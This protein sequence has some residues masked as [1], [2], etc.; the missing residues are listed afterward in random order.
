MGWYQSK[1]FNTR[2]EPPGPATA[3][4]SRTRH[5]RLSASPDSPAI[6]SRRGARATPFSLT[7]AREHASQGWPRPE[8]CGH[9][10]RGSRSAGDGEVERSSPS[11]LTRS[12]VEVRVPTRRALR[13]RSFV[14]VH[15]AVRRLRARRP[16]SLRFAPSRAVLAL[17]AYACRRGLLGA[18][19]AGWE[20]ASGWWS[21]QGAAPP[22]WERR[23]SDSW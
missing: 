3:S 12:Q 2:F 17:Y 11:R 8:R 14:S 5:A 21:R 16:A 4:A 9:R 13:P 10:S 18:R 19:R 23:R 20:P 6:P 7:P 15:S 22:P 1:D